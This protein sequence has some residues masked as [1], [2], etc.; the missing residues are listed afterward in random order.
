MADENKIRQALKK[1]GFEFPVMRD[2]DEKSVR[3][4]VC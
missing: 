1:E 2:K 3:L 4:H